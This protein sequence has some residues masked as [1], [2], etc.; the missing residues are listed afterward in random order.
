MTLNPRRP[1]ICAVRGGL[2]LPRLRPAVHRGL[3]P[4]TPDLQGRHPSAA[5]QALF[6][7]AGTADAWSATSGT[8]SSSM[9]D[10]WIR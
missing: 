8:L 5:L 4:S 2:A 6:T 3:S 10:W 1:K 7:Q 9:L